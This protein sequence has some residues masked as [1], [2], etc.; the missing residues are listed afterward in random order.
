[1]MEKRDWEEFRNIKLLWWVNR[2]LHIF[3]WAIVISEDAVGNIEAY[4]ARVSCRGFDSVT[5]ELGFSGLTE[6]IKDNAD[7]LYKEAKFF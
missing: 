2:T 5:E 4:P 6:Y 1:M 7:S 3:G